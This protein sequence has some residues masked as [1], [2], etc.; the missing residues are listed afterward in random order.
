M[1]DPL[2]PNPYKT[3]NLPKDATLATIRSAH[4]KLVL[5]CHPDKVQDESAKEAKAE[6]FHQVQQAYEILSDEKRRQRYDERVKLEELRAEMASER[7]PPVSRRAPDYD[8]DYGPPRG[9]R[10]HM[11]DRYERPRYETR[12]PPR[13]NRYSDEDYPSTKYD[14]RPSA[15]GYDDYFSPSQGRRSF[16][17]VPDEKKKTRDFEDDRDRRR[18]EREQEAALR[19]QRTK[20]RDQEKRRSTEAKSKNK[21]SPYIEDESDSE[22]DGYRQSSKRETPLKARYEEVPVSRRS[23]EEPRKGSKYD[24]DEDSELGYK[25]SASREHIQ[26]T[27][28]TVEIE[29]RRNVRSRA[30][31]DLRPQKK[32]PPPPPA[33]VELNK[34]P[35]ARRGQTSRPPSPVRSTKKDKRTPTIVEPETT[36]KPSMP[37]AQSESKGIKSLFNSSRGEPRRSATYQPTSDP[38][39]P[40]M[41]R[42]ETMPVDRMHP[43]NT[44]PLKSSTLQNMKSP[45]DYSDSSDSDSDISEEDIVMPLR[46]SKQQPKATSYRVRQDEENFTLE[47]QEIFPPRHRETSPKSRRTPDRPAM[48]ARGATTHSPS[49]ARANTGFP[50]P[51]DERVPRPNISRT[52]SARPTPPKSVQREKYFGEISS[53]GLSRARH[54]SRN[55]PEDVPYSGRRGSKDVS[56]DHYPGSNWAEHRR[57]PQMAR[58]GTSVY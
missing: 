55:Y 39:Q 16:G 25:I 28:G 35:S 4:R 49:L 47:P 36:R 24:D 19:D 14:I 46:T 21:F 31:S 12:E 56:P 9:G 50:F 37:T 3:L 5:S 10:P 23:R 53:D 18:R 44:V 45:S 33:P 15:K 6:Q 13:S 32:T 57:R 42:S 51:K 20:K 7:E 38:K 30:P 48:A 34:R 8:Y 29:P 26:R 54:S 11:P 17:R 41:R 22:Y 1:D 27:R 43:S 52:E 58:N 40:Q 2:P